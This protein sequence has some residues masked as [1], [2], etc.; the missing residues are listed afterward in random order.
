MPFA[1]IDSN[2]AI[3]STFK[4]GDGSIRSCSRLAKLCHTDQQPSNGLL[5][6]MNL[7]GF[8]QEDF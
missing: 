1:V 6:A 7:Q 3:T 8:E 5:K 2:T 4:G